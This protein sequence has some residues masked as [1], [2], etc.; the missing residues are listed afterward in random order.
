MKESCH[1]YERVVSHIWMSHV[2]HTNESFHTSVQEDTK[3][4]VKRH[5]VNVG[6]MTP[7]N[8]RHVS[9]WLIHLR[10]VRDWFISR[11][12]DSS[13]CRT[14]HF[15]IHDITYFHVWHDVFTC[16]TRF[17]YEWVMSHMW[18][19]HVT[20]MNESCHTY[21]W[22]MSRIWMSH[23]TH[24]NESCHT[25]DTIRSCAQ[26]ESVIWHLRGN[27]SFIGLFCRALLQKRPICLSFLLTEAT[28]Y[29]VWHDSFTC[30]TRLTHVC[31]MTQSCGIWEGITLL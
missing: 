19:S 25:Y 30:M 9:F 12:R 28:P 17:V 13:I 2:T 27:H 26:Y 7:S 5:Y 14:W 18:M 24:M 23:V 29:H 6:D 4:K 22:V 3:R 20:H 11:V 1:K 31:N 16:M 10:G 8:T 21:E 15:P